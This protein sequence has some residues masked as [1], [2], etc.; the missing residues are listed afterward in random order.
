MITMQVNDGILRFES[1]KFDF[2]VYTLNFASGYGG[3]THIR[4]A[5][6]P[7]TTRKSDLKMKKS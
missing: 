1:L 5:F 4:P 2:K 3:L 7:K 6:L